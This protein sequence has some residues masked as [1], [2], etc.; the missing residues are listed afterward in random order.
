M[1][2]MGGKPL[3]IK[4]EEAYRVA[5]EIAEHTGKSLTRV[6]LE[7][8]R[9]EKDRVAPRKPDQS[10]IR[11]ILKQAHSLPDLD[12]RS[13]REILDGLYDERGFWR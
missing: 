1:E 9:A 7:A 6:V 8:L 2:E 11:R 4:N 3:N 10:R 12:P 13:G 5:S